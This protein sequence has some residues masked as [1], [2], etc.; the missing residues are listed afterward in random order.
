M[1]NRVTTTPSNIIAEASP[2]PNTSLE[3]EAS[4]PLAMP[5]PQDL[6]SS[7]ALPRWVSD[8][9]TRLKQQTATLT[10]QAAQ[11]ADLHHL[12]FGRPQAQPITDFDPRSPSTLKDP[13]YRNS[14]GQ[15]LLQ[16][17]ADR[18]HQACLLNIVKRVHDVNRQ[19]AVAHH[20]CSVEHWISKV[21]YST[22]N[23]QLKPHK[24]RSTAAAN[25]DDSMAGAEA[26]FTA[27]S[28]NLDPS[29]LSTSS[30]TDGISAPATQ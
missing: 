23:L 20:F 2:L 14:S 1:S 29:F 7:R 15:T 25:P 4:S 26:Q 5:S 19:I 22:F 30:P 11:I 27:P 12:A 18:I 9:F 3:T 13:N 8:I 24:T 28:N 21:Q 10:A 16:E 17:E 6:H